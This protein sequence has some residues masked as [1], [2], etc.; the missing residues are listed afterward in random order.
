MSRRAKTASEHRRDGTWRADRHSDRLD[1]LVEPSDPIM[2]DGL[3]EEQK[4]V[5]RLATNCLPAEALVEGDSL[6][7]EGLVVWWDLFSRLSAQLKDTDV[8]AK[9][10]YS[11]IVQAGQCWNN[12]AAILGKFGLSPS[13]R[14]KIKGLGG[15]LREPLD[16]LD[17]MELA[18]S[19]AMEKTERERL[20]DASVYA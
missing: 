2:P 5:W 14:A 11:L 13:D 16:E 20:S 7:L 1:M 10:R 19:R 12:C 17:T 9:E 3:S 15:D 6:Y 18:R 8:G 4:R